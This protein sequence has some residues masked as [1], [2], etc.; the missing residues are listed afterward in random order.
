[1]L[2]TRRLRSNKLGELISEDKIY[3]NDAE[4]RAFY[5]I[6]YVALQDT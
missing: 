4:T 5:K 1:M 3:K 2:Y 6:T